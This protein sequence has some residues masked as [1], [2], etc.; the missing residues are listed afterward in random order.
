MIK[1][2]PVRTEDDLVNFVVKKAPLYAIEQEV[3]GVRK[4][5]TA[6]LRRSSADPT[7]PT[8]TQDMKALKAKL[9]GLRAEIERLKGGR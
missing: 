6:C 9:D 8:H 3:K 7:N 2:P 4:A 5:M 1:N